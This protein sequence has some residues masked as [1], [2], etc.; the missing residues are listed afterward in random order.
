MNTPCSRAFPQVPRGKVT[1]LIGP[2]GAGKTTTLRLMGV[3]SAQQGQVL[4]DGQDVGSLPQEQLMRRADAWACCSSL[5]R[6]LPT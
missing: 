5:A 6:C 2:M 4:F 3:S 1:A